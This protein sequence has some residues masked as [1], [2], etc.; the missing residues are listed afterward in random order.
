M[1]IYVLYKRRPARLVIVPKMP[2]SWGASVGPVWALGA[3]HVA[4]RLGQLCDIFPQ[5]VDV[6]LCYWVVW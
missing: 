4:Y 2:P 6:C 1:R 3:L 5:V